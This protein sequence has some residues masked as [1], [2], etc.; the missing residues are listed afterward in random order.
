[1]ELLQPRV[2]LNNHHLPLGRPK[3]GDTRKLPLQKVDVKAS[4]SERPIDSLRY[5][6]TE[7]KGA[8]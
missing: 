3:A 5:E 1:M 6:S 7:H 2:A 4:P 8:Q